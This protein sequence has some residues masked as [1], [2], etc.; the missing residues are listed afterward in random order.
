[1]TRVAHAGVGGWGRNVARVVG[2]LAELAWICDV[3]AERRDEYARRYPEARPTASLLGRTASRI[4]AW[5]R[6]YWAS[7]SPT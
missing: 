2:E 7:G 4:V 5:A 3:D 6:A 1:M